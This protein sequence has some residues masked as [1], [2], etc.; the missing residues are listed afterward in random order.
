ML[1]SSVKARPRA[2]LSFAKI[3][4]FRFSGTGDDRRSPRSLL[5]TQ[6]PIARSKH[7]HFS[8][9]LIRRPNQPPDALLNLGGPRLFSLA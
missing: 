8:T 5:A 9:L 4:G 2:G 7:T 6:L 1:G 3:L